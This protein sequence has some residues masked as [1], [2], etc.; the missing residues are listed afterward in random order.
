MLQNINSSCFVYLKNRNIRIIL[1]FFPTVPT[2]SQLPIP[3]KNTP[4][5]L[6]LILPLCPMI[7]AVQAIFTSYLNTT[8]AF[9]LFS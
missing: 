4:V 6:L 9:E 8:I 7:L 2:S 3:I 5:F 1:D